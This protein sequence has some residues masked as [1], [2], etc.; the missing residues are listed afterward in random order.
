M[1][2]IL[3]FVRLPNTKH[4]HNKRFKNIDVSLF[5]NKTMININSK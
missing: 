4:M 3:D 1:A 2:K 5:L